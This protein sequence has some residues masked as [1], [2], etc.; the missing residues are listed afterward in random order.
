MNKTSKNTLTDLSNPSET[1]LLVDKPKGISSYDVIR[2]LQ[3]ELGKKKMGHAG[4]L[5]PLASGLMIIGIES[6][7]KK[8]SELIGLNK[9]YVVEILLGTK[10][11]TGD[12]DGGVIESKEV[13]EISEDT[14]RDTT[15]KIVG[16][17]RLPV[18]AFSA[19]KQG[20]VP[21]YKKARAGK[22]IIIPI[23]DMEVLAVRF[24]EYN[25]KEKIVKLEMD[26]ASGVYVRSVAEKFGELLDLPATVYELR[27]TKVGEF[28]VEDARQLR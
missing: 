2:I 28:S 5:D 3:R 12:L 20:G 24:L 15:Q 1:L 7:T 26:V 23:R 4:T 13:G 8:L 17:L 19:V 6:G 27:R 9:T 21:L 14:L 25:H 22:K 18:P 11:S 10:T 16:V